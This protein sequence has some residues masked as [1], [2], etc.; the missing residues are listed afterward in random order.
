ML[1]PVGFSGKR[2]ERSSKMANSASSIPHFIG[3][4][5]S[6]PAIRA[7]IVGQDGS[8]TERREAPLDR[9]RVVEQ[10]AQVVTELRDVAP[11][12]A[13]VGVAIPGLV[14][15]QTDRVVASRNLPS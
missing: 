1:R 13:A 6:G 2:V 15:R 12:I 4:D 9:E 10:L 8:T 5:L 7:A 14:N 3:I 11:G